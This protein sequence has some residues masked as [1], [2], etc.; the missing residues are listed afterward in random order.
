[1]KIKLTALGIRQHWFEKSLRGYNVSEVRSFLNHVAS[2]WEH[3]VGRIHILQ[4]EVEKLNAKLEQ[5]QKVEGALHET[6][7]TASNSAEEKL[8]GAKKEAQTIVEKAEMDAEAILNESSR[9][10]IE[11]RQDIHLLTEK[12]EEIIR[13]IKSYLENTREF[14]NHFEEDES[15]VFSLPGEETGDAPQAGNEKKKNGADNMSGSDVGSGP[16]I[17]DILDQ[18]D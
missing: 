16:D 10:R 7:Q 14:L 12:R 11:I 6:L 17:D 4:T 9:K 8:T 3:L 1:M 15:G 13:E 5:Y 2:E 18:L